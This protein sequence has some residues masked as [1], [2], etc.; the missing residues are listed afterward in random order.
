MEFECCYAFS[1]V[2]TIFH[3]GILEIGLCRTGKQSKILLVFCGFY[4]P[5]DDDYYRRRALGVPR[6]SVRNISN[7]WNLIITSELIIKQ[8]TDAG[9]TI[10]SDKEQE[11]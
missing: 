1:F 10:P 4:L 5:L 2:D 3:D 9:I 6:S 7:V 11:K 8:Q